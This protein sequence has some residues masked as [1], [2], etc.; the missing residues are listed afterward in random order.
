MKTQTRAKTSSLPTSICNK[1][2]LFGAVALILCLTCAGSW[3]VLKGH[4]AVA[5][6]VAG[7]PD[8]LAATPPTPARRSASDAEIERWAGQVQQKPKDDKAWVSLGDAYM[9]KARETADLSYYGRAEQSYRQSLAVNPKRVDAMIGLAW[10]NGGRHE[11]EKS[12][13]WAH[14]AIALD[15]RNNEAYGLLGDA[16]VEMGNYDA[17]FQ[18]YQQMLDIRPDLASYS[19][20]AHLLHLNGDIRKGAWLMDKAIKAG[21]PYAE[22]TAWCRAQLG[23]IAFS[24]GA[25][26]GA[27]QV[28]TEGLKQTPNNYHLLAAMGRVKAAEKQYDAAIDSYTKAIAIAPQIDAVVALGD[29]YT[30]TGKP[31]EA[32]K[33][34]ALVETIDKLNKANGVRGDMQIALFY[35]NHDR[36]L[37]EAL[38][39]AEEEYQTRKNI[40]AADTL[41]WCYYK[42]GRY[43]DAKRMI[44]LA[45]SHKTPEALFQF[46]KGM[47]CAKMGDEQAARQILYEALSLNANFHPIYAAQ[48]VAKINELGAHRISAQQAAFRR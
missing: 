2:T 40:Y 34:Y 21:G 25:Y 17:A 6:Q 15:A 9:Q 48:A 7:S 28:L 39:M 38:R 46:H 43:A 4:A 1:A 23:L 24:N 8:K 45:L 13:E 5:H 3:A 26:W 41:A 22:N 35:A 32:A 44:D 42:N 33:Q 20:G 12:Q 19:R 10:V 27:D 16:D 11:F 30:V 47:I 29:L 14:K 18:D 31:K 36:N 37:P